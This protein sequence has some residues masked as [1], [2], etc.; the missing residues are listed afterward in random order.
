MPEYDFMR[1]ATDNDNFKSNSI[2]V[3]RI[4]YFRK[5]PRI[6]KRRLYSQIVPL[7]QKSRDSSRQSLEIKFRLSLIGRANGCAGVGWFAVR[8]AT[9]LAFCADRERSTNLSISNSNCCFH[10]SS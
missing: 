4:L 1:T 6:A 10:L 7:G 3:H 8:S 5:L 2:S 9:T